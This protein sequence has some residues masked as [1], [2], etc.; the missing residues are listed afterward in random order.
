[1]AAWSR[2]SK[3]VSTLI[4]KDETVDLDYTVLKSING[5]VNGSPDVES[6]RWEG[7]GKG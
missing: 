4:G 7:Q 2:V 3:G 1:M 6:E 5:Y